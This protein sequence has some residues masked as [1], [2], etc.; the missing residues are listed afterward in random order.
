MDTKNIF[1]C[2]CALNKQN[3]IVMLKGFLLSKSYTEFIVEFALCVV[4]VA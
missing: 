2:V 1:L 3:S 4:T